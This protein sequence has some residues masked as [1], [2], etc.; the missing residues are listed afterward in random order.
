MEHRARRL[1]L[2]Q[3][4]ASGARPRPRALPLP[5]AAGCRCGALG[6]RLGRGRDRDEDAVGLPVAGAHVGELE[7]HHRPVLDDGARLCHPP[8]H[9]PRLVPGR[10]VGGAWLAAAPT[11]YGSKVSGRGSEHALGDALERRLVAGAVA[12]PRGLTRGD[13]ARRGDRHQRRLVVVIPRAA[14][15]DGEGHD[16]PRG[17]Q[18][19]RRGDRGRLGAAGGGG[20]RQRGRA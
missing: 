6:P 18:A 3:R 10:G 19:R 7:R 9:A 1:V 17:A 16:A 13:A 12:A 8:P 2:E 15:D 11:S 4:L 5:P 20:A 14:V